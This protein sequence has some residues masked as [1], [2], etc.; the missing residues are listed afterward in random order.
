MRSLILLL[1]VFFASQAI[2]IHDYSWYV[3]NSEMDGEWQ[4]VWTEDLNNV[5]I[6]EF[7]IMKLQS[8]LSP[9]DKYYGDYSALISDSM[10]NKV[11]A[12][13]ELTKKCSTDSWSMAVTRVTEAE[14]KTILV[15][16]SP[17]AT[18]RD[19]FVKIGIASG[20]RLLIRDDSALYLDDPW[21]EL[22]WENEKIL[23]RTLLSRAMG[24]YSP[25]N[26]STLKLL[27]DPVK[28]TD[29]TIKMLEQIVHIITADITHHGFYA[30]KKWLDL[31][32]K[33]KGATSK[34]ATLYG[35]G[36]LAY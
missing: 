1:G 29:E 14:D 27:P 23:D 3:E 13:K 24:Y 8:Y 7:I 33:E 36:P 20:D 22:P 18:Y 32:L 19:L 21:N 16:I 35:E 9:S 30:A 17:L 26:H 28:M 10:K 11:S 31:V 5:A 25:Y 34:K 12:L 6:V 2:G 4:N 15:K